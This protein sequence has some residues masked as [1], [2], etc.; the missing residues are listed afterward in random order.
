MMYCRECKI[1][2]SIIFNDNFTISFECGC[3]LI[4]YISIKEFINDYINKEKSNIKKE[5]YL[6]HCKYHFKQT[7]FIKYCIDCESDLCIDCLDD[8]YF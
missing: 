2:C 5:K 7:E 8:K 3:S 1:P 6:M 4:K